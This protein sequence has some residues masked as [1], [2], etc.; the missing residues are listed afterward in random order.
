VKAH[1]YP[2]QELKRRAMSWAVRLKV[3]P[4]ALRFE[5][6]RDRWGYCS[7]AGEVTLAL[8]LVDKDEP[9]Q[10]YVIVHELLHLRVRSHGKRFRA[11]LSAY[12]PD[13]RDLD[14]PDPTRGGREV[15]RPERGKRRG[16]SDERMPGADTADEE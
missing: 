9:F 2:E 7:P 12:I 16:A 13:W 1:L 5:E 15:R 11:L 4:R 14:E 8:D 3:N 6:L 10:D